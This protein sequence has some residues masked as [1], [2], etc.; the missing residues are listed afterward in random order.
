MAVADLWAV[1]FLLLAFAGG[2]FGAAVGALQSFSLAGLVVIVGEVYAL[3]HRSAGAGPP[4]V[5]VTGSVGFGPVLGPHVAFGGGAAAVAFAARQGYLDTD[6]EYHDAKLV[7]R[8]L[9]ARPDVLAVGGAFGVVGYWVA[10]ASAT[11]GV[12][13]DPVALGVVLSALAHRVALGYDV[14]GAPLSRVFD[15]SP[16]ERGERRAAAGTGAESAPGEGS[17]EATA[18]APDGGEGRLAVEPWLAYQYRWSG[19]TVL[20]GVVGI[21]G[22]YLAYL[23]GS[24]FLAFGISVVALAFLCA[25][26]AEIPVTHHMSLPASTVV[27]GS[28][29][30][31]TPLAPGAVAGAMPLSEAV[32]LGALFGVV[33]ALLGEAAQRVLYAHADT[34]LDPPAASIVLTSLLIGGLALV[35]VLPESAWI[36]LPA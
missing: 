16:F 29:D 12:P 20:G 22:G 19:V 1:E 23:T 24:A 11:L 7:T 17:G 26:V 21:L 34:H 5:D 32:L 33:G 2:A 10:T 35:G 4:P 28:A 15:M 6:F 18:T 25:D 14:I 36:P 13:T 8:G 3:V 27:V 30:V 31:A 9:G